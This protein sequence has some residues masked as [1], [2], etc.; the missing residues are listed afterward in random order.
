[1]DPCSTAVATPFLNGQ[2]KKF[3]TMPEKFL[4]MFLKTPDYFEICF[5]CCIKIKNKVYQV[6][7][8]EIIFTDF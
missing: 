1:L 8:V 4:A 6:V 7:F 2:N 3:L 5:R